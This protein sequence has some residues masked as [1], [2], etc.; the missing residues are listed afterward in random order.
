MRECRLCPRECG[1]D[2]IAGERGICG[3]SDQIILARAAL[4]FWE[5]PVISGKNGSGAV[6][7]SGCRLGCVYC[8][9]AEISSGKKGDLCGRAVTTEQ[10]TRIFLRLQD[11]EGAN[12]INL[13]TAAH[14]L[15]QVSE[16]IR[17]AKEKGLKIPVIYN[18]SGYEK[19]ESLRLLEG[20]V[21][22]YLPDFKYMSPDLS[23]HLSHAPDYPE[24]AKAAI[25]EMVRQVGGL[26]FR[27]E[28]RKTVPSGL[29]GT[30]RASQGTRSPYEEEGSENTQS[31]LIQRGVIVRHLL[32]PGHVREAKAVVR[33][34]YET[35]GNKIM[36]SMMNQYTPMDRVREDPL[37]GRKVTEREY[38]RLWEYALEI[39]VENGFIQEGKTA[40]ESFIPSWDGT[41][42]L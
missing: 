15:P 29:S 19:V 12:N 10:L 25:R 39:G 31:S 26:R 1:V 38:R 24:I 9:N 20:L 35:Y 13:V 6:F 32:L 27:Q 28:T 30:P 7:F 17:R 5:E 14:F 23:G 37:L 22:V 42:I 40:E 11:R 33:Y 16:A 3:A 4:H 8:Q 41:G 21:D 18:S 36:I 34:L 2:R